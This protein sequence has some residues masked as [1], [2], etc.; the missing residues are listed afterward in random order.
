MSTHHSEFSPR[1]K[2]RGLIE[3]T[4]DRDLSA[5]STVSPRSKDRGLIEAWATT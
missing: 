4:S 3:A 1:S 2:D 5:A